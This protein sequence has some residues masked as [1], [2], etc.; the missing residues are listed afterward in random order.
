MN[1]IMNPYPNCNKLKVL[2]ITREIPYPFDRNGETKVIFPIL[3]YLNKYYKIDLLFSAFKQ[4]PPNPEHINILKGMCEN[5][6]TFKARKNLLFRYLTAIF[7]KLPLVF[8]L[9]SNSSFRNDIYP[10]IEKNLHS[11]DAIIISDS[12]MA[13]FISKFNLS[14]NT[15]KVFVPMD[16]LYLQF[17][18]IADVTNNVLS[19]FYH[20]LT[21][22]KLLRY[23]HQIY[24]SFDKVI[25]V[26]SKDKELFEKQHPELSDRITNVPIGIELPKYSMIEPAS[27]QL[28]N[29]IV[30]VGNMNYEPNRI[31]VNWFYK[32]VFLKLRKKIKGITWLIVGK[33]AD[34][35]ITIKNPSIKIHS[36]V[37]S[38]ERFILKST[39]VISPLQGGTGLK[40]KVLEA[41]GF[42]K[43]VVG[44]PISFDGINIEQCIHAVI[45]AEPDDYISNI[46]SLLKD[47]IKRKKIEREAYLFVKENFE[48]SIVLEKWRSLIESN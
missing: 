26:S 25:F 21:S 39:L 19:K 40:N 20:W 10:L 15:L 4:N 37:P 6:I 9:Y 42:S 33:D 5:V 32:E 17:K 13:R 31:A 48:M 38:V 1:V 47:S 34:K 12:H 36:S 45:A 11:Y 29:S 27:P 41:M 8:V 24:R 43:V 44:S 28:S 30:F 23:E 46:E 18:R 3:K 14:N 16:Y 7:H 35:Y 22:K 2:L